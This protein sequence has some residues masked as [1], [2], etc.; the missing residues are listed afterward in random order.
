MTSRFIKF[1]S[2]ALRRLRPGEKITEHGITAERQADGDLRYTINI[3][4]DGRRVHRVI[5]RQAE[6]ARGQAQNK[7]QTNR[8]YFHALHPAFSL[9]RRQR[10]FPSK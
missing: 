2:L 10:R 1:D 6:C 9:G 4:V 5:G 8:F 3:M 7:S